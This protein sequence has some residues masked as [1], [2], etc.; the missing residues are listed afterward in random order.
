MV[1]KKV[2]RV[3][4]FMGLIGIT[5]DLDEDD[6]NFYIR[7]VGALNYNKIGINIVNNEGSDEF[8]TP[9]LRVADMTKSVFYH[10]TSRDHMTILMKKIDKLKVADPKKLNAQGIVSIDKYMLIILEHQHMLLGKIR[11][12]ISDV[13]NAS[14]LDGN[15]TLEFF[16]FYILFKIIEPK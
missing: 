3:H 9:Y 13:F 5:K 10:N 15:K 12:Y 1:Y 7:I 8:F 11:D 4:L 6:A 14:D 16:E 2:P